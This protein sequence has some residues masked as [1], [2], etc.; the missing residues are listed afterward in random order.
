MMLARY[1]VAFAPWLL[2]CPL[3]FVRVLQGGSAVR[4]FFFCWLLLVSWMSVFAIGI[5]Y[6]AYQVSP[7]F[8]RSMSSWLP[9]G[10][11]VVAIVFVG[12]VY[13]GPTVLL[14]LFVRRMLKGSSCRRRGKGE[15]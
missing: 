10:P 11:A 8:A 2:A 7:D 1:I 4:A 13:A 14:A 9:E 15:E 6:I 3:P 12:W 5:P